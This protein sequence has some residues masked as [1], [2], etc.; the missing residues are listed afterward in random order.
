MSASVASA[1]GMVGDV[2]VVGMVVGHGPDDAELVAQVVPQ[3]PVATVLHDRALEAGRRLGGNVAGIDVEPL[4]HR[5]ARLGK[6]LNGV[7][8]DDLVGNAQVLQQRLVGELV[9]AR[10]VAAQV[11][12][13]AVGRL[14]VQCGQHPLARGHRFLAGN[15]CRAHADSCLRG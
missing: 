10:L 5:L 2:H 8:D 9:D 12:R 15:C 13:H 6:L 14:V 7:H 3:P 4:E 11:D 1:S